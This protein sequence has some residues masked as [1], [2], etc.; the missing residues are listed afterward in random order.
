MGRVVKKTRVVEIYCKKIFLAPVQRTTL[1]LITPTPP[2]QLRGG[3]RF[4][5]SLIWEGLQG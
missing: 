4:F 5:N 2:P 3:I 1:R